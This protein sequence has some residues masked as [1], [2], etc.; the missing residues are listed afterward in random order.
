MSEEPER[1]P[2][3][4]RAAGMMAVPT[5]FLTLLILGYVVAHG[6]E[7]EEEALRSNLP[8]L[9]AISHGSTFALLLFALRD[10]GRSLADLGWRIGGEGGGA[11]SVVLVGV[12]AALSLYLWKEFVWD[13]I[14]LIVSGSSPSFTSLFHFRFLAAEIPLLVVS[15]TLGP[16]VEESVY[17]GYGLQALEARWGPA[18][19]LVTMGLLFALLHWGN[20]GLSMIFTGVMG[21]AFGGLFIWRRSLVVPALAHGLYNFLVVLT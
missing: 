17:R 7:V 15:A 11:R 8:Y 19:A 12:A 4:G 14:R 2:S 18:A 21:V 6:G 13:S 10:E 1:S 5:V 16:V 3:A 9:I 20:G